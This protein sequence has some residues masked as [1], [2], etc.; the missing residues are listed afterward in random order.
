MNI[1]F[2]F[3]RLQEIFD[4]TVD[5]SNVYLFGALKDICDDINECLGNVNNIEPVVDENNIIHFIDQT[6]I[7]GIEEIAKVLE[8]PDFDIKEQ[9]KLIIYGYEGNRSN[10]VRKIGLTTEIS[11]NYAT[12]ITIGATANGAIPGV[13]ATAFSRWNVG[14][15]DR[16]K[17]N[18][19]DA[20]AQEGEELEPIKT[21]SGQEIQKTYATLL[22][23]T[24]GKGKGFGLFGLSN[25]NSEYQINEDDIE[26][27]AGIIEDFYKL[28]Q[29]QNSYKDEKDETGNTIESSVGFLPFNLKLD[30]DGISGIK[31]YNKIMIQQNFLPSNYPEALEFI[32]TQVNHKLQNNDWVTSLET[33][34]TS[35]SVLTDKKKKPTPSK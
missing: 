4:T 23:E 27:N 20:T 17:N 24:V 10:F 8:L 7:P 19:M 29:S 26:Y 22:K 12:M 31:I 16:F 25:Q 34:A 35:K 18:V 2:S 21:V 11:K 14:I 15:T 30:L 3:E 5:K 9:E 28:M 33:I 13:E 1:Y 32:V 6:Q